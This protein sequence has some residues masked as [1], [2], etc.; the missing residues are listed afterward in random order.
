[1]GLIEGGKKQRSILFLYFSILEM[2]ERHRQ[3][4]K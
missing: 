2:L 3:G 1:M 4:I